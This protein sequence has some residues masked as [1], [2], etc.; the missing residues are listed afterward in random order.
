MIYWKKKVMEE[1]LKILKEK[2][3]SD[4]VVCPPSPPNQ[5]EK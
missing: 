2:S 1:K 4:E 3:S 5:H